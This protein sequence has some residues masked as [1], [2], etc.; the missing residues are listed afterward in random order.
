MDFF[1]FYYLGNE[2]ATAIKHYPI[3]LILIIIQLQKS[4][5]FGLFA[6]R[7]EFS[8]DLWQAWQVRLLR[9]GQHH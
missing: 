9:F 4:G 3:L 6:P 8:L 2:L 1:A 7:G 5:I